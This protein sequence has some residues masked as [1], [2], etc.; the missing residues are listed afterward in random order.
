MIDRL[1]RFIDS[2][3]N[4]FRAKCDRC[5]GPVFRRYFGYYEEK[6]ALWCP[7]CGW[8]IKNY[9]NDQTQD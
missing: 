6:S 5:G 9:G 8:R 2:L 7:N 4:P 1:L 3:L